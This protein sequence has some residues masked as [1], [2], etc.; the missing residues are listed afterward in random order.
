VRTTPLKDAFVAGARGAATFDHSGKLRRIK[1]HRPMWRFPPPGNSVSLRLS[2]DA[3]G[4]LRMTR[5]SPA[6]A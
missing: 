3:F 5:L 1:A 6:F 4:R 2:N